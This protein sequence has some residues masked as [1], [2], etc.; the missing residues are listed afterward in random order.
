MNYEDAFEGIICIDAMENV[1]PEDWMLVLRNFHKALKANGYLYFTVELIDEK[2]LT[3]A[4]I[5]GK[6]MGLPIVEGEFAHEEGYHYYPSI[7]KV[8][9]WLCEVG[10]K[11]ISED[12]SD[13][14]YHF[15]VRKA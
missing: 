12:L 7:D 8:K 13:G 3:E 14:Y 4:Y 1:F 9:K 11:I 5:K 15:L 2:E 10:F 6:E